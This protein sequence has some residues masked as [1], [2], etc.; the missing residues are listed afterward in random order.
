MIYHVCPILLADFITLFVS[1]TQVIYVL[2]YQLNPCLNKANPNSFAFKQVFHSY[3][4]EA[5]LGNAKAEYYVAEGY[6]YGVGTNIDLEKAHYWLEKSA[7]QNDTTAMYKLGMIYYSGG[8]D[9][10]QNT[11]DSEKKA[12]YWLSKAAKLGESR[13]Q[14][15]LSTLY[16]LG[17]G[18]IKKDLKISYYWLMC[19]VKQNNADAFASLGDYY[20]S[21]IYAEVSTQKV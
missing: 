1:I 14:L 15:M 16:A 12:V 20:Y 8:L 17:W 3:L 2:E 9:L 5:M 11:Q 4:S 19:A 7:I 18:E 6:F 21:G 10:P 13:S